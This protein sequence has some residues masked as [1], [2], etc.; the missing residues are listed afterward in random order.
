MFVCYWSMEKIYS[1][2]NMEGYM[3]RYLANLKFGTPTHIYTYTPIY[4][5]CFLIKIRK[6]LI[7]ASIH[8][9][10]SWIR[11]KEA[12][13]RQSILR[14]NLPLEGHLL[15]NFSTRPCFGLHP[16]DIPHYN[17]RPIIRRLVTVTVSKFKIAVTIFEIS[18]HENVGYKN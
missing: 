17:K 11:V 3:T 1:M 13:S 2:C 12:F 10:L 18:I 15:K 16:E 5:D 6:C 4:I 14:I 7:F 8:R 9:F